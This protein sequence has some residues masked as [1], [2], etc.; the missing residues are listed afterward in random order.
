MTKSDTLL[1]TGAA[2]LLLRCSAKTVE[3]MADRG[4]LA[5]A[6]L[7]DGGHRRFDRAAVE[8]LAKGRAA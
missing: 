7:T 8:A 6:C 1:S 5:V 3:R 4:D 2:A